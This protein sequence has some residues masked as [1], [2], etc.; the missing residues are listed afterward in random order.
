MVATDADI[1]EWLGQEETLDPASLVE[2]RER[3]VRCICELTL[4]FDRISLLHV[5]RNVEGV[6]LLTLQC[7][8]RVV[9]DGCPL[10]RVERD[11]QMRAI[12]QHVGDEA[13]QFSI[14]R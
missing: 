7:V 6:M 12:F 9:N 10:T 8:G 5:D 3:L 4:D 13:P 1:E 14:N 2:P 11:S